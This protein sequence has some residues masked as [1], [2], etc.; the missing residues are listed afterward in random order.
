MFFIVENVTAVKSVSTTSLE[1]KRARM[2]TVPILI[3]V[4]AKLLSG[5]F[6]D[7]LEITLSFRRLH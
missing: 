5:P 4:G 2:T 3:D 7:F 1:A 6:K